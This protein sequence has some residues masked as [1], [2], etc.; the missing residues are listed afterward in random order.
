MMNGGIEALPTAIGKV[1]WIVASSNRSFKLGE[2]ARSLG[3]LVNDRPAA[4]VVDSSMKAP[5][6]PMHIAIDGV[7]GAPHPTW[8]VEVAND[9]FMAPSFAAMAIGSAAETTTS[10][11]RDMTWR[12]VSKLE[13]AKF[14]TVS[15]VDFGSGNGNPISGDDFSRGRLVRAMGALLNNPWEDVTIKS[16]DTTMKVDFER[17]VSTLRGAKI[18][19]P[20]IDAGQPAR[21]ELRLQAYRG[22]IE[23]QVIE[24]PIPA[25]LAG[26]EVEIELAP[27]YEVDRTLPTPDSLADLVAT[28]PQQ[29]FDPQSVVATF[30]LRENGIAFHGKLVSRLPPGVFDSLRPTNESD[31]P[32]SFVAQVQTAVPLKRFLVGKDTVRVEVRPVLR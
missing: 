14:G 29:T 21:I 2:A 24:V 13:I 6:F 31:A 18:I 19:D 23:T 22:A 17:D 9:P 5:V 3:T 15:L 26:H 20:E 11:R 10:E 30:R 28:L 27:G 4:I 25:E 8:N 7:E 1:H 32:E 12:A 16:I